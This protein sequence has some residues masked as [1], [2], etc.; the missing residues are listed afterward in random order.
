MLAAGFPCNS[1]SIHG[2]MQ[3][4]KCSK[5]GDLGGYVVKVAAAK[6]PIAILMENVPMFVHHTKPWYQ[7]MKDAL[8]EAGY[9]CS[10][11]ILSAWD[12]GLPQ[13][14]S[15][16]FIVAMREDVPGAPFDFPRSP[17][18]VQ[19]TLRSCLLP[20]DSERLEKVD[21]FGQGGFEMRWRKVPSPGPALRDIVDRVPSGWGTREGLIK[22]GS[23]EDLG[24]KRRGGVYHD[25]G[26]HPCITTEIVPTWI[27]TPGTDDE[28]PVVRKLDMHE[29]R[30][31]QGFPD[32]FE[33]HP[34]KQVCSRQLGNAV[35]PPMVEWVGRA[36]AEQFREA[37]GDGDDGDEAK[38][39]KSQ[40]TSQKSNRT[41]K[42]KS[43]RTHESRP[44]S[45]PKSS[46][47]PKQ[48]SEQSHK[49]RHRL[50]R[51]RR[52]SFDSDEARPPKR[53]HR[54]S[55]TRRDSQHSVPTGRAG[56]DGNPSRDAQ[57]RV[58][59]GR[60]E[61]DGNLSRDAQPMAPT[62]KARISQRCTGPRAG[63]D[64]SLGRDAKPRVRTGRAG[65]DRNPGRDAQPSVPTGRAQTD[66]DSSRDLRARA[67]AVRA[68][69]DGN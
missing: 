59:T 25:L 50:R 55:S 3:G 14:R 64:G 42:D 15:R 4:E 69:F 5:Y 7:N 29:V 17:Q 19:V 26:H 38:K 8:S 32:D 53:R 37:F 57:P 41:S 1:F 20:A 36:V 33:I 54:L 22:L 24:R 18:G 46:G 16:A 48:T 49:S 30:R 28:G 6:R 40:K 63:F 35:P 9:V 47:K 68:G 60:A 2:N 52:P 34:R 21:K 43:E 10:F 11:N 66:G 23:S 44:K 65:L 58:P 67:R 61:T 39:P 12:F 45:S 51:K 13:H 62:G 27:L 31:I 56:F